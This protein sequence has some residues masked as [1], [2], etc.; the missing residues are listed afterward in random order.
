MAGRQCMFDASIIPSLCHFPK[1]KTRRYLHI[2]EHLT[3]NKV[4]TAELCG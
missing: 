3:G 4:N 1:K 2:C